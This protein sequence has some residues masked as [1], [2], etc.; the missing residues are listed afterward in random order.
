MGFTAWLAETDI[1]M[2]IYLFSWP[3]QGI[4]SFCIRDQIRA[5][6][7]TY[8]ASQSS[9]GAASPVAAQW[10]CHVSSFPGRREA[11]ISLSSPVG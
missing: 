5:V 1:F 3:L 2:F 4:L 11:G 9:Q 7:S 10:G 6:V 8:T